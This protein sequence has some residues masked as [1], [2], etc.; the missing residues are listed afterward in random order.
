MKLS[1][2]SLWGENVLVS[3]SHLIVF[4]L[5]IVADV[6]G[7]VYIPYRYDDTHVNSYAYAVKH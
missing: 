5:A 4:Y 6:S 1:Q 2:A 7:N 3:R